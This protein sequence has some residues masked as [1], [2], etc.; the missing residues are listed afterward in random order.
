MLI[1][2]PSMARMK[3]GS[4]GGIKEVLKLYNGRLSTQVKGAIL[5]PLFKISS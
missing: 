1:M 3:S 2:W 4:E 5:R